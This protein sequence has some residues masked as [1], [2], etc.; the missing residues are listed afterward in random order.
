MRIYRSSEILRELKIPFYT[1]EYWIRTG[2][3]QPITDGRRPGRERRF[4]GE[5][6]RKAK[7]LARFTQSRIRQYG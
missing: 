5:E 6:F 4:T 2:K 1:L 7:E 3:V